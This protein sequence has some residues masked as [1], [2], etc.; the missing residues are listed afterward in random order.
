MPAPKEQSLTFQTECAHA[1]LWYS[2]AVYSNSVEYTGA[3]FMAN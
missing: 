2:L 3:I 1:A